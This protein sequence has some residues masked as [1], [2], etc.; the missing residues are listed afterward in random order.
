MATLNGALFDSNPTLPL[1]GD[2]D[3][4]PKPRRRGGKKSSEGTSDKRKQSLY[5]PD[6]M[7]DEVKEEARRL[8]RSISWVMQRA[9]AMSKEGIRTLPATGDTDD[10]E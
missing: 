10:S 3:E 8:D 2:D 6:S 1:T 7:I 4:A 5:M 9:W